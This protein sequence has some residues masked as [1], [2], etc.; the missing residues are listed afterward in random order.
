MPGGL[1]LLG[2]NMVTLD[3]KLKNVGTFNG[4]L[5]RKRLDYE[6]AKQGLVLIDEEM[7]SLE[8]TFKVET[9]FDR[10]SL[11]SQPTDTSFELGNVTFNVRSQK[12]IKM[13]R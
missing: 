10:F 1:L 12:R 11:P 5:K 7:A 8:E 2:D 9:G 4:N 6:R 3:G 13:T